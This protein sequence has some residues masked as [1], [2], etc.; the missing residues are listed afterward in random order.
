MIYVAPKMRGFELQRM[1]KIGDIVIYPTPCSSLFW[2]ND[3]DIQIYWFHLQSLSFT[4]L[5][6]TTRK[7]G[8]LWSSIPVS[9]FYSAV[10]IQNFSLLIAIPIRSSYYGNVSGSINTGTVPWVRLLSR[11]HYRTH[12]RYRSV[13]S[14]LAVPP[15][16]PHSSVL[17]PARKTTGTKSILFWQLMTF[18]NFSVL[19]SWRWLSCQ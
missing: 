11:V 3:D 13:G 2:I 4:T 5:T 7:G 6:T 19:W 10:I 8:I 17:H 18:R 9:F 12:G 15:R 14:R 1:D 16:S